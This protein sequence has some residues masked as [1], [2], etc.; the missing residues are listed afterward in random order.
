MVALAAQRS[1][2]ARA[3]MIMYYDMLWHHLQSHALYNTC[4]RIICYHMLSTT[5][6]LN[7]ML[8]STCNRCS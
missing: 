5:H 2:E 8:S 7:Y 1:Q 4:S 6:A 3:N